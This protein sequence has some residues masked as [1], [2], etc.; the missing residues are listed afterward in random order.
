MTK[1]K[2]EV[3]TPLRN[4]RAKVGQPDKGKGKMPEGE[5]SQKP[6]KCYFACRPIRVT[7]P[8]DPARMDRLRKEH[9]EDGLHRPVGCGLAPRGVGLV[10]RGLG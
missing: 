2:A 3:T 9:E 8:Q 10:T 4:T 1:R 7:L 6:A 5:S